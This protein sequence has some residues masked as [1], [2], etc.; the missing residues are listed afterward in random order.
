MKN[1]LFIAVFCWTFLGTQ[2]IAQNSINHFPSSHVREIMTAWDQQLGYYLYDASV[3]VITGESYPTVPENARLTPFEYIK[4]MPEERLERIQRAAEVALEEE[5][6]SGVSRENAYWEHWINWSNSANCSMNRGRSNGD[7]HMT[8]YDGKRYDFQTAGDYLLSANDSGFE[9][10]TRQVRHNDKISVNGGMS[11]YVN[12][13]VIE[14]YVQGPE[15]AL[16]NGITLYINGEIVSNK[17]DKFKLANGGT[18]HASEKA[19]EINWPQGEQ[20][21]IRHGSFQKSQLM[22]ADIFVPSCRQNYFG[23]L[24]DNDGNK[25]NDL[26]IRNPANEGWTNI[27]P[28]RS[29]NNIFGAGRNNPVV[30]NAERE[31][32]RFISTSFGDQYIVSDEANLFANPWTDIPEFVRYPVMNLTLADLTDEQ[33][34]EGLQLAR[35]KGVEEEDLFAAVF[36]YG[37]VGLEPELPATYTG[38]ENV[39]TFLKEREE[40]NTQE[41]NQAV[42]PNRNDN[43]M[44]PPP[45]RNRGTMP[46]P[47][48]RAPTT[49]PSG[50]NQGGRTPSNSQ[51]T[52]GRG[53]RNSNATGNTGRGSGAISSPR[54]SNNNSGSSGR[55]GGR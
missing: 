39:S 14:V 36:D 44:P 43:F 7:P 21:I 53:G 37:F 48:Y 16:E 5:L 3:A 45:R 1:L 19:I 29:R 46:P 31:K 20:A 26:I 11:L 13:D 25:D 51:E 49:A 24:G 40:S 22:N 15:A 12:G 34:E 17:K 54:G 32:L 30:Q 52:S 33:I 35:E 41:P 38:D 6:Q 47:I 50:V 27:S 10:H 8:T 4:S 9:I 28:D 55:R 42:T 18:V 23:L 2:A